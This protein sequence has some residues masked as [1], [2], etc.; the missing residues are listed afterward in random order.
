MTWSSDEYQNSSE[1]KSSTFVMALSII[2][3][4]VKVKSNENLVG[5]NRNFVHGGLRMSP[6]DQKHN[7]KFKISI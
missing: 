6:S 2:A 4:I 5:C 7:S 3:F 1:A